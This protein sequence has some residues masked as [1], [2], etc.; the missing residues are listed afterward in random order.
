MFI[1]TRCCNVV[2]FLSSFMCNLYHS[3]LSNDECFLD[4][5]DTFDTYATCLLEIASCLHVRPCNSD[6]R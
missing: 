2:L 6:M 3:L 1:C 5:L 4:S